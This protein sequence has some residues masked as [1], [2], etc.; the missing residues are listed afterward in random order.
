MYYNILK[1]KHNSVNTLRIIRMNS[2]L[3]LKPLVDLFFIEVEGLNIQIKQYQEE[4]AKLK[5]ENKELISTLIK[6]EYEL[7]KCSNWMK[8]EHYQPQQQ[9]QQHNEE[10]VQ[11]EQQ[12]QQQQKEEKQETQ[13]DNQEKPK[14]DRKEYMR[15]YQ[16]QY[17]K[18]KRQQQTQPV[19]MT[20]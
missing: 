13:Q 18:A 9:P 12:E 11:Q 6:Y 2:I 10:P 15:E 16:R 20:T 14:R 3:H 19:E 4:I 17:R 5:S 1:R 7:E 8:E